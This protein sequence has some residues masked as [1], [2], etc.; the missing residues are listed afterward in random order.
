MAL[1]AGREIW[2]NFRCT[3]HGVRVHEEE[4]VMDMTKERI[5]FPVGAGAAL[6]LLLALMFFY[7]KSPVFYVV[8][9]GVL[10]YVLKL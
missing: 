4:T 6:A 9:S 5:C 7:K 1:A 2:H 3:G 8:L 10:G